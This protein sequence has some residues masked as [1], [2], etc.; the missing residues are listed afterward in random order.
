MGSLIDELQ[1]RE[2]TARAEAE[3]L[4]RRI[5]EL[6]GRP[7]GVQ[8][9]LS[10][11]VIAREMVDEIA[12]GAGGR[13]RAAASEQ[14]RLPSRSGGSGRGSC[15][16][17]GGSARPGGGPGLLLVRGR[18]G[19]AGSARPRTRDQG[20][21]QMAEGRHRRHPQRASRPARRRGP[22]HLGDAP[23]G[24]Q[25]GPGRHPPG[26]FGHHAA[27]RARRERGR[28]A[29]LRA[30]GHEPG[31]GQCA[32]PERL[33]PRATLPAS[34]FRFLVIDDPVQAMDPAKVD[35]LARVL[36]RTVAV[37]QVIVF[38][39]TTAWPRRSASSPY[40]PPSSR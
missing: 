4:R 6:D 40:R 17:V 23:P 13:C 30:R 18:G 21:R 19:G 12:A 20:R 1:R 9:R 35:G 25:R 26:R 7:A 28:R 33:P 16:R 27:C 3:E 37:R 14:R 29:R 39:T 10:R 24:E 2:A 31:R 15:G 34:P 38:T 11:L 36:H 22:R 8:E 5:A 32:G